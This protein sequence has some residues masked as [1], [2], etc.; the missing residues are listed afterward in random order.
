MYVGM[1]YILYNDLSQEKR[2]IN[3][4]LCPLTLKD[5][6]WSLHYTTLHYTTLHT[7]TASPP[8]LFPFTIFFIGKL[9]S[10]FVL[11]YSIG[12]SKNN[13]IK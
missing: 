11:F 9:K 2:S 6:I 8:A 12:P 13:A 3:M 1:K 10:Y 5:L 4:L 7:N